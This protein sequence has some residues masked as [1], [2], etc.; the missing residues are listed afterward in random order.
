MDAGVELSVSR[1]PVDDGV[2]AL[3]QVVGVAIHELELPLHSDR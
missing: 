2:G 3:A 1:G